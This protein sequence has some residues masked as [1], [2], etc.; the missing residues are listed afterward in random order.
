ML[1]G[2]GADLDLTPTLRASINAN[3]LQFADTATL[4]AARMQAGIDREIGL[5]LSLALTWRPLASQNIV[6]RLS[7][8]ALVPGRG[9]E[10]LYG[11]GTPYSILGNVVFTY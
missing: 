9:F 6:V 7:A 10:D 1:I 8:A 4:E 2:A 5:D 3:Y 11:S